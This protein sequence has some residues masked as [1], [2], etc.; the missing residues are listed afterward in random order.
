[1]SFKKI[2]IHLREMTIHDT[3]RKYNVKVTVFICNT[4]KK[5][6]A[7]CISTVNRKYLTTSI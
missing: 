1:M 7:S 4:Q 3:K 6:P 5:K 2:S